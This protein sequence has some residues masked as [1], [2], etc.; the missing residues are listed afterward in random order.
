MSNECREDGWYVDVDVALS[1]FFSVTVLGVLTT[2]FDVR[3]RHPLRCFSLFS[4]VV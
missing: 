2:T 3:H 4:I 1:L